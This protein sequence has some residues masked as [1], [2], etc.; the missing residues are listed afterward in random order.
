[1]GWFVGGEGGLR[2]EN[3]RNQLCYRQEEG[4]GLGIR[5]IHDNTFC[6]RG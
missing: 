4:R 6:Y 1:M 2:E 5:E 3:S